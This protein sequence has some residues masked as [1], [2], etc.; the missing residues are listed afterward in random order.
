M[1]KQEK[2]DIFWILING[3]LVI[4]IVIEIIYR[5]GEKTL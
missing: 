1:S 4:W 2:E 5:I 3:F